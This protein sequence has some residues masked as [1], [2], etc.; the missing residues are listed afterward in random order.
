MEA[1]NRCCQ[2]KT[3]GVKGS[4]GYF[5]FV[6]G[7]EHGK[8][9]FE[10]KSGVESDYFSFGVWTNLIPKEAENRRKGVEKGGER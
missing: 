7:G 2:A 4:K 3:K 9:T 6:S 10:E 5:L 1:E 8:G